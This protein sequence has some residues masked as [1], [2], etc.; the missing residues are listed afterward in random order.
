MTLASKV[1]KAAMAK[2]ATLFETMLPDLQLW[3]NKQTLRVF[4]VEIQGHDDVYISFLRE[5][6]TGFFTATSTSFFS[7]QVPVL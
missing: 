2:V 4:L 5:K 3:P 1:M 7:S 6:A